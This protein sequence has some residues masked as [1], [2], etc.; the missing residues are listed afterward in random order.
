MEA[1][2]NIIMINDSG[3]TPR[4]IITEHGRLTVDNIDANVQN[5]IGQQTRQAQNSVQLFHCLTKSM[6]EAE[7]LKIVA[8]PSKYMDDE[9]PAGDILFK[10]MMQKSIIETRATAT[11]LRENLTNLYT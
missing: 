4:N 10:L 9:T 7:H 5:F 6:S 11:H 3:G 8:E 1:R 2:A